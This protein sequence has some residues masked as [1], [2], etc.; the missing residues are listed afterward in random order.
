MK[1]FFFLSA[2]FLFIIFF[3]ANFVFAQNELEVQYPEIGGLKPTTTAS[4]AINF[5]NYVKYLFVFIV[6]AGSFVA[7]GVLIYGGFRYLISR[8]SPAG[9]ADAK[10]RMGAAALGLLILFGSYLILTTLNPQL[11]FIKIPNLQKLPKL[12]MPTWSSPFQ[13]NTWDATEIPAGGLIERVLFE[14]NELSSGKITKINSVFEISRRQPIKDILAEK[15]TDKI[16][17]IAGEIKKISAKLVISQEAASGNPA[18]YSP[19]LGIEKESNNCSCTCSLTTQCARLWSREYN[20]YCA[21]NC[22]STVMGEGDNIAITNDPC[23]P[24]FT[25][26]KE[27]CYAEAYCARG[28]CDAVCY[29]MCFIPGNPREEIKNYQK[30]IR[31]ITTELNFWK[32]TANEEIVDLEKDLVELK[33]AADM[34][35]TGCGSGET[36]M[37]Y[38]DF[39]GNINVFKDQLHLIKGIN[40]QQ[41]WKDIPSDNSTTFYCTSGYITVPQ[42]GILGINEKEIAKSVSQAE[43]QGPQKVEELENNCGKEIPIG[44]AIDDTLFFGQTILDNLKELGDDISS[45]NY[46]SGPEVLLNK[47]NVIVSVGLKGNFQNAPVYVKD[48][49]LTINYE[50]AGKNKSYSFVDQKE[51][52]TFGMV[53][54]IPGT[55]TFAFISAMTFP[56]FALPEGATLKRVYWSGGVRGSGYLHLAGATGTQI[57]GEVII[58]SGSSE[59]KTITVSANPGQIELIAKISQLANECKADQCQGRCVMSKWDQSGNC[60][61]VGDFCQSSKS[62]FSNDACP[63]ARGP[64]TDRACREI[65]FGEE[66]K[67]EPIATYGQPYRECQYKE[68]PYAAR[69]VADA[70]KR[71]DGEYMRYYLKKDKKTEGAYQRVMNLFNKKMPIYGAPA[72]TDCDASPSSQYCKIKLDEI[73]G[74]LNLARSELGTEKC[75]NSEADWL[76]LG[77]NED[78]S[79]KELHTCQEVQNKPNFLGETNE[80]IKACYTPD[81][82]NPDRSENYFCCQA[83]TKKKAGQ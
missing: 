69:Q 76:K 32:E 14:K 46:V 16:K 59:M 21:A 25:Q 74:N 75:L 7:F 6:S 26:G 71:I 83:S 22:K 78:V 44:Q 77:R 23:S 18:V 31:Q 3:A 60:A 68:I 9:L 62:S 13:K 33:K 50:V 80:E 55:V 2:L 48:Q 58:N 10:E 4:A 35:R 51:Y 57:G 11:A 79:M 65:L 37:T 56:Y 17:D 73:V 81:S 41:P 30:E 82:Q 29:G 36:V 64:I 8:G 20:F 49:T 5:L 43:S 38:A 28:A 42:E 72:D 19:A 54:E 66:T 63:V 1:R 61:P 70:H 24:I 39:R 34:I 27:P 53:E 52:T 45:P 40:L 15:R 67:G 47:N 12:S